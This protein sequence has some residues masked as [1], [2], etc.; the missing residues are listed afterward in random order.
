MSNGESGS[1]AQHPNEAE[2]R[3]NALAFIRHTSAFVYSEV[4]YARLIAVVHDGLSGPI[5][6]R[7]RR[8]G[9]VS[10]KSLRL[11][12]VRS[13]QITLAIP[14]LWQVVDWR[15]SC[16]TGHEGSGAT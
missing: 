10:I 16:P 2:R 12:G 1:Q 7:E 14:K 5:E 13:Y 9:L 8:A 3:A 6:P 11:P 4:D 15:V